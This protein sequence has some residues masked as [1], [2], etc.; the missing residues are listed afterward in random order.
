MP[1]CGE[2]QNPALAALGNQGTA[3]VVAVDPGK[4]TVE[5]HHVVGGV[6]NVGEGLMACRR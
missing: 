1:R 6:R 3:H 5:D 2:N 4:V